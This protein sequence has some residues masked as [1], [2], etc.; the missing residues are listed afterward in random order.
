[1]PLTPGRLRERLEAL[2][3]SR[4]SAGLFLD[5]DGT[6]SDVVARPELAAPRPEAPELL[7]RLADAY[8]LVAVVSGRPAGQIRDLLGVATVAVFGLYG[9]EGSE[10][11]P[12]VRGARGEVERAASA[13]GGAWV[14]DK[15]ASLAVH[16]RGVPDPVAAENEI[17]RALTA[18]V[19]AHGLVLLRGKMVLEVAPADLPGKGSVVVREAGAARLR[20]AL[21]AGDDRADLDAFAALDRLTREGLD[22][23]K[24][25]VRSE[26]TPG[27]LVAEADA[28]VERPAGLVRLLADLTP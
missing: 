17:S 14:E 28:V 25:A 4:T 1:V 23:L 8:R 26:E 16:Y 10:V 6:L 9:L 22:T 20:A 3:R 2:R 12:A 18:L 27:D 11:P 5:F 15:G 24:I 19:A 13:V 21:Y 7:A